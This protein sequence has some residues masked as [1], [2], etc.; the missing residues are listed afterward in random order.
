ME[1]FHI[2][3]NAFTK[4]ITS[5]WFSESAESAVVFWVFVFVL[6]KQLKIIFRPKRHVSGW[7]IRPSSPGRTYRP[8]LKQRL[9]PPSS[10][11]IE[12]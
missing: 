2:N 5:I 7:Q 8:D 11:I 6:N 1:I 3:V 9:G 4:K 10:N 12:A